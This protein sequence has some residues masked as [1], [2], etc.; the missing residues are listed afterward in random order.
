MLFISTYPIFIFIFVRFHFVFPGISTEWTHLSNNLPSIFRQEWTFSSIIS[1]F[2]P[3]SSIELLFFSVIIFSIPLILA[4]F[5]D[6]TLSCVSFIINID[7]L[8]V[9]I[10]LIYSFF[11]CLLSI[12]PI[13]ISSVS[14][15]HLILLIFYILCFWLC[16]SISPYFFFTTTLPTF[17]LFLSI[18]Y[19]S[20]FVLQLLFDILLLSFIFPPWSK[21]TII[22]SSLAFFTFHF[23][24]NYSNFEHI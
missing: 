13:S 12:F 15:I 14:I 11:T 24:W 8:L 5:I 18:S 23:V 21:P 2:L 6:T 9:S 17:S 7:L 22:T 10:S 4:I 1:I 20:F 3:I 16:P 19:L